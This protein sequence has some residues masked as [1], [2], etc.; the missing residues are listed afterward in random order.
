MNDMELLICVIITYITIVYIFPIFDL[1]VQLLNCK[2]SDKANEFQIA[3][4]TQVKEFEAKYPDEKQILQEAIGFHYE[5]PNS[6]LDEK[7]IVKTK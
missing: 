4:K 6:L 7:M 5:Q 3:S 2:I 1:L